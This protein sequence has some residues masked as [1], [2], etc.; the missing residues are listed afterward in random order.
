MVCEDCDDVNGCLVAGANRDDF[1][2]NNELYARYVSSAFQGQGVGHL[3]MEEYKKIINNA[4][5][6]LFA[7][8]GNDKAGAFYE[9]MGGHHE[10]KYD[11]LLKIGDYDIPEVCYVFK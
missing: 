3:L 7:L 2:F 10:S 1:G 11:R 5:F 4:G 6:Y 9:K 8:K